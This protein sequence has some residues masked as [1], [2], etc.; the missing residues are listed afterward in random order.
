[1]RQPKDIDWKV[2]GTLPQGLATHDYHLV[3][4]DPITRGIQT[5]VRFSKGYTLP[6]HQH[7]HDETIIVLKGKLAITMDG[8]TATL[9]SGAYAVIPAGT[10][11]LLRVEGWSGCEL[12]VSF[13][14]PMD[15][16]PAAETARP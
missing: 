6:L 14:G 15:F 10:P 7:S 9:G 16:K 13:S 8:K 5:F 12:I 3:Y 1:M 11:H 4:E 2:S